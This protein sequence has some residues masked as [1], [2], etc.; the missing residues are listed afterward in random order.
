MLDPMILGWA[1]GLLG[2]LKQGKGLVA[3][4][5]GPNSTIRA[6]ARL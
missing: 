3:L 6:R 2:P 1:E 5:K 4:E